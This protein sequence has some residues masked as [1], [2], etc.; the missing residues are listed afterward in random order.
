MRTRS[1]VVVPTT[2]VRLSDLMK[3]KCR[4]ALDKCSA[5]RRG[6]K[7]AAT[8][9]NSLIRWFFWHLELFA[10]NWLICFLDAGDDWVLKIPNGGRRAHGC[11]LYGFPTERQGPAGETTIGA[12]SVN[13]ET[14]GPV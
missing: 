14:I 6:T 3:G 2:M 11:S 10:S 4:P 5:D 13:T 9:S 8:I 7:A 1:A 12:W